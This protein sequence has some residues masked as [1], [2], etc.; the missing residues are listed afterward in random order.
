M[1]TKKKRGSGGG[2]EN[3]NGGGADL[4]AR[5]AVLEALIGVAHLML[6]RKLAGQGLNG[7][8]QTGGKERWAPGAG[9]FVQAWHALAEETLAP[10]ADNWRGVSKRATMSSLS[11]PAGA[12]SV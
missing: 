11:S 4:A 10:F 8:H 12:Y 1:A 3:G 7:D 9:A 6:I 5:I 2:G